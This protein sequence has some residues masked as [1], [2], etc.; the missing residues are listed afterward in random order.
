MEQYSTDVLGRILTLD[1]GQWPAVCAFAWAEQTA[2]RQDMWPQGRLGSSLRYR[3][4]G[5]SLLRR[6]RGC[7]RCRW[8]QPDWSDA[9]HVTLVAR[10][11]DDRIAP[12]AGPALARIYLRTQVAVVAR[13]AV[14]LVGGQ[15]APPPLQV[16][17]LSQVLMALDP[18]AA[19]RSCWST[20]SCSSPAGRPGSCWR[21]WWYRLCRRHSY[22]RCGS[23]PGTDPPD[24]LD[25]RN[26][27]RPLCTWTT[28][29]WRVY[30]HCPPARL[31]A[32]PAGSSPF[33]GYSTPV[34]P[35]CSSDKAACF[36]LVRER[37]SL[38]L[39]GR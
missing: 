16:S 12:G 33:L 19:P 34:E 13:R 23:L 30:T 39:V 5:R 28:A 2:Q 20:P 17:G 21:G 15:A 6:Y 29:W 9:R 11:A 31:E 22:G 27:G 37:P 14:K 8:G 35:S 36:L 26:T 3:W 1:V 10:R 18:H 32:R 25:Q 38:V 24:T 7:R 4:H